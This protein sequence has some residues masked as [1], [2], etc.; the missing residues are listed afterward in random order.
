MGAVCEC[1]DSDSNDG[2][3]NNKMRSKLLTSND[4]T[5]E[6]LSPTFTREDIADWRNCGLLIP[7]EPLRQGLETLVE[8]T[9]LRHYEDGDAKQWEKQINVFYQWYNDIF[10]FYVHHHHDAEEEIYFPWLADRIKASGATL[11]QKLTLDHQELMELM[12]AIKNGKDNF[13]DADSGTLKVGEFSGHLRELHSACT[14]LRN[15]MVQHL[16]EEEETVPGLLR[17]NGVT[18]EEEQAVVQQ[19]VEKLGMGGNK[20]ALPWIIDSMRRWGGQEMVDEFMA[21]LPAPVRWLMKWSWNDHFVEYNKGILKR[22]TS[23]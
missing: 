12:D 14:K 2:D 8:I 4:N 21:A 6:M 19:I 17:E 1:G 22:L 3:M 18:H 10:Y 20:V 13:F 5:F 7:H 16:N 9:D 23:A 15:E 11:P